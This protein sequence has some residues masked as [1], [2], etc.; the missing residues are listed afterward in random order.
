MPRYVF[1][2]E[3][4]QFYRDLQ[5]FLNKMKSGVD[6]VSLLTGKGDFSGC[7]REEKLRGEAPVHLNPTEPNPHPTRLVPMLRVQSAPRM[8]S[9]SEPRNV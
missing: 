7:P 2:A 9:S 8:Y 1:E 3:K 4:F 5:L 6:Q